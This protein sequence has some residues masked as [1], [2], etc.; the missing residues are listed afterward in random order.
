[1][2]V[3]RKIGSSSLVS[4]AWVGNKGTHLPSAMQP[5]NYLNPSLLTSMGSAELNSV[6]QPG[7]TTLYGV[8]A[9]YSNWVST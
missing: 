7:Q 8:S 5:L 2:T 4:V 3:E 1:M 6:F 9:P